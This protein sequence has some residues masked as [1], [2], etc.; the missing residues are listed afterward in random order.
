MSHNPASVE[1][2]TTCIENIRQ[3]I[4]ECESL[5][6]KTESVKDDIKS[7][8]VEY[9]EHILYVTLELLSASISGMY[10]SYSGLLHIL[11][12]D[13]IYEKRY[14]MQ[15][16]NLCQYEWCK[17]F[18][19]EES[20]LLTN[21]NKL[22]CDNVDF[23][24]AIHILLEHINEL[25]GIC[26]KELRNMTAHYDK[27]K[28]MYEKLVRLDSEDDYVKRIS[29]QMD[30]HKS[31]LCISDDILNLIISHFS[32]NKPHTEFNNSAYKINITD[33]SNEYIYKSIDKQAYLSTI[34]S[35]TLSDA[36]M[37]IESAKKEYYMTEQYILRLKARDFNTDR[38][39]Y[40]KSVVELRWATMFLRFDL[41][42]C[43]RAYLNA[44][45]TIERSIILRRVYMIETSALTHLYG[46]NENRRKYSIWQKL[47]QLTENKS[48]PLFE[49]LETELGQYTK[50][51][52]CEK[53]NV[54]IHFMED[55]GDSA[56]SQNNISTRWKMFCDMN[57]SKELFHIYKLIVLCNH[58]DTYI[59]EI[60]NNIKLNLKQSV[61]NSLAP[62]IFIRDY[63]EKYQ[64]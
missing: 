24:K 36:W 41:T 53:R 2:I 22:F 15:L 32:I 57:H 13:S 37:N 21:L 34:C 52:N 27:P 64:V 28:D 17:L 5:L 54:L 14:H 7:K 9:T 38:L 29:K 33:I 6:M 49:Q 4:K 25:I 61:I 47:K 45:T 10:E 16:V 30:I 44:T 11:Q 19:Q 60:I 35:S 43:M 42:C 46:Y 62:L 39:E 51:L 58:I 18:T 8:L 20:G 63:V 59:C 23:V 56:N 40:L 31:I 1:T 12:T 48:H 26:D 50:S 3:Q 55:K